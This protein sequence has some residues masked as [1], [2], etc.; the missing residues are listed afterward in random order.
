[1][2]KNNHYILLLWGTNFDEAAAGICEEDVL[3]YPKCSALPDFV[4]NLVHILV[5]Y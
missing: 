1:M 3:V 5:V 2:A 4:R